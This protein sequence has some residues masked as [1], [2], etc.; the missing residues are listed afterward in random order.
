MRMPGT[1]L[2]IN[3]VFELLENERMCKKQKKYTYLKSRDKIHFW[4]EECYIENERESAHYYKT[5]HIC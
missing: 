2:T 1:V 3:L 4:R 5:Y